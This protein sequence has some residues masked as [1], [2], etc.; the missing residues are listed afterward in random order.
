MINM[1]L[2]TNFTIAIIAFAALGFVLTPRVLG[3]VL[4]LRGQGKGSSPVPV[5]YNAILVFSRPC[6]MLSTFHIPVLFIA[7]TPFGFIAFSVLLIVNF[8]FL[9]LVYSVLPLVCSYFLF[10]FFSVSLIAFLA[11][12]MECIFC[13]IGSG[14]V[15]SSGRLGFFALVATLEGYILGYGTMVLHK[16]F[17]LSLPSPGVLQHRQDISISPV[18][19]TSYR[20]KSLV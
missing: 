15:F 18:N 19:Y 6:P 7:Q 3:S 16:K 5:G 20:S 17:N 10:V 2:V 13:F 1:V 9:W 11:F 14:K 8:L 4:S 12:G